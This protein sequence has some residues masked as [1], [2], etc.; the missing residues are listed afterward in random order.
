MKHKVKTNKNYLQKTAYQLNEMPPIYKSLKLKNTSF[1]QRRQ[2][3]IC[4]HM[5]T[6]A[7][8]S[9]PHLYDVSFGSRYYISD[10]N[11]LS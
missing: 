5:P 4:L 11:G 8:S 1:F 9:L 10:V 7:I 2:L 3:H 6:N